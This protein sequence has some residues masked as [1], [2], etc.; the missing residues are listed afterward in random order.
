MGDVY[1]TKIAKFFP[2]NPVSNSEME[3]YLGLISERH[4]KT[5]GVVLRNNKIKNRY[6]ALNKQGVATHTNAQITAESVRALFSEN[7]K[8]IEEVDLLSCGTSLADQIMPSHAVMTHGHLP[9]MRSVEVTSPAG[10]CCAGMHAL[11]Y[12]YLGVKAGENKKAVA[13]GSERFS[14]NLLANK[15]QGEAENI[16]K[17]SENPYI[18]FEKDFLRWMLSDGAGSMLLEDKKSETGFSYKIEW[19]EGVSF[20]NVKET[21]MY[22]GAVKNEDTSLTGYLDMSSDELINTSAL[23]IKQDVTLLSE[24]I[25]GLGFARLKEILDEKGITPDD[26]DHMLP[27]ISSFYFEEKIY[28]IFK[29][30]GMEIPKEKWFINLDRVGNV[31]A[32]SIYLMLEELHHSDKLK[33]G[34]KI[35]L[36]VPESARFSYMFA[37]LTVC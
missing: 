25:L 8:E 7:P 26:I 23:A 4:S 28:D 34:D 14:V 6:Y 27:H 33:L 21:C 32:A 35:L 16:D 30:N 24:N 3:D 11:K 5:K 18:A 1:I 2:N 12:A 20:A 36:V 10:V 15:F 19:I 22:A 13:V 17:L 29:N 37:W 9:E 31:G